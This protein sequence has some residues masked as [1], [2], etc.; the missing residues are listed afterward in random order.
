[1]FNRIEEAIEDIK[2]GKMIIVVDDEDREN[3]GDLYIPTEDATPEAINFMI[4]HGKGLVCVP[5]E[6]ELADRLCIYDMVSKNTDAKCTAFTQTIDHVDTKTGI[7]AYERSYTIQKLIED[8]AKPNDF[9]RP[10]HIFPLV[11]KK[12]GVLKRNG[13][14][15][16][17]IDLS[18]LAG[19]HP[20]GVICEIVDE[21]GT[22]AKRDRLLEFAEK[23]SLKIITIEALIKHI[24]KNQ[25]LV[26]GSETAKLMTKYGEFNIRAYKDQLS[27]EEHVAVFMGENFS[28]EEETLVRIHSECMTGDVFGSMRCD[29]GNQLEKAMKMISEKKK[30]VVVYMRQEGRGIGIF[31]KI[32]A[33][34]LQDKGRDTVEANLELGFE[35][36]Q[37]EYSVA[38][39][40]LRDMNIKKVDLI[41]NNPLKI[42]GLKEMGVDVSSRTKIYEGVCDHNRR[43]MDTKILKMKHII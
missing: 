26:E 25:I 17:S 32:N 40:I 12:G 19:K 18:K 13:H 22:M 8:D 39:M 28:E 33:Y 10:G 9:S 34:N 6:E 2:M 42:D 23:F 1:M 5:I 29:C 31:N 35:E 3:E 7:S 4:T 43:Y 14:T 36:D 21:D 15:E 41:T 38:S 16:A 20:S 24:K 30:G 27:G 37:R 11:A